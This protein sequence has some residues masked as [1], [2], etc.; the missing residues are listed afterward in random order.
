ML[1]PGAM[2]I[3]AGVGAGQ[4]AGEGLPSAG[5]GRSEGEVPEVPGYRLTTPVGRGSNGPVWRAIPDDGG[6][7][8]AVKVLPLADQA[9]RELAILRGLRHPHVVGLRDAVLLPDGRQVALVLDLVEGGS[10]GDLVH[11]RG[12]LR[13]GEV[14]TVIAPLAGALADLHGHGI[15][16]GDLAPGN[17]LFDASGRPLL[18]DLGTVRITGE[19]RD[20]VFGTPGFVDPVVLTGG[21]AGPSSDV[22]GLGALAWFGLTGAAPPAPLLRGPLADEV[23]GLPEALVR[24][25]EAALSPEPSMR[26]S[27][28]GLAA[29]IFEA[30]PAEPVWLRGS[31]PADGGLTH[32]IRALAA[33]PEPEGRTRRRRRR[34]QPWVVV[35]AAATVILAAVVAAAA[36]VVV[37]RGRADGGS[38]AARGVGQAVGPAAAAP[39]EEVRSLDA[40]GSADRRVDGLRGAGGPAQAPTGGASAG[41]PG[42][43]ASV[44]TAESADGLV[45]RLSLSRGAAF[46]TADLDR[47]DEVAEAGSPAAAA[48]R[49]AVGALRARGVLYRGLRLVPSSVRLVRSRPGEAVVDVVADTSAY[50][51]VDQAGAVL[52]SVPAHRGARSRL[53][54]VTTPAG[55]RVR[56]VGA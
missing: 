48:D 13:P 26:P 10:L 6:P 8:V 24:V 12:H 20:E 32:R 14:V 47:L 9:E 46:A 50:D 28:A 16:H 51:V 18:A 34:W 23:P 45:R 21:P 41:V 49:A 38:S 31:T 4:S 5:P 30:T 27:P 52:M 22:Y 19:P 3:A 55:W 36:G 53:V 37:Y 43:T 42:V 54:L 11:A 1:H 40:P 44:L 39:A 7:D 2:D 25:V 56:S 15:E 17:V 35:V 29:E 33:E